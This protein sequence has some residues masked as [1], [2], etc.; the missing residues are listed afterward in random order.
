MSDSSV[1]DVKT[2]TGKVKWFNSK[3]GYGFI[4]LLDEGDLKGK[5]IFVHHSVLSVKGEIY[6]YLVQGEYVN[7][8]VDFLKDKEHEYQAKNVRG[9]MDEDL[10]CET[11]FKN[12]DDKKGSDQIRVKNT[13]KPRAVEK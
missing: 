4:S 10:M 8:G 13:R 6:K 1:T 2:Y 12:K 7:L 9:V 3:S 11:R 5:D